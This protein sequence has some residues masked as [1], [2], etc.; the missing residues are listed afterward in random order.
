MVTRAKTAKKDE[1]LQ[2]SAA[3]AK[4]PGAAK[5]NIP[6]RA[7]KAAPVE[8]KPAKTKMVRDSFTMPETDYAQ[9]EELKKRC[10]HAGVHVKKSELLRAGLLTLSRLS[11]NA[12]VRAVDG[13]EK[14]KTGRPAKE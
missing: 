8:N 2:A 13:V 5:K 10:L 1:P 14:L 3:P 6:A 11:D 7:T 12:L 4:A 9:L